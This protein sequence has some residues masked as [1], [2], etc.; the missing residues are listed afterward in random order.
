[1]NYLFDVNALLSLCHDGPHRPRL[2][3][4][5]GRQSD[6]R[7]H[8]CAIT[9]LGFLRISMGVYKFDRATA[10][11]AL[12]D[13]KRDMHG[14]LDTLPPPA[15]AAW[16]DTHGK[17]T[18]TYLCQLAAANGMKLVTFDTAIKDKAALVIP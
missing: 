2:R 17:T 11:R 12:A 1:M 15:L 14:Y 13:A 9:E 4:W 7:Y 16:C 8:T 10:M 6:A 18:D 5:M 3:V